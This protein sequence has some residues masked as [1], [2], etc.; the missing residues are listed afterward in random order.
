MTLVS[1][2]QQRCKKAERKKASKREGVSEKDISFLQGPVGPHRRIVSESATGDAAESSPIYVAVKPLFPG[3]CFG[4]GSADHSAD[5]HQVR[6]GATSHGSGQ[7]LIAFASPATI[8]SSN[9]HPAYHTA[10]RFLNRPDSP[11][12]P[13]TKGARKLLMVSSKND[14]DQEI[15]IAICATYSKALQ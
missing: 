12:I 4:K 3:I 9:H 13:M 7:M 15:V 1:S 6:R 11:W 5:S 8:K 2:G 14:I 10:I